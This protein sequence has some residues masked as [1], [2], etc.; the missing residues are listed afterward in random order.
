VSQEIGLISKSAV[1]LAGM[2]EII[3]YLEVVGKG[4]GDCFYS[5]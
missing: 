4:H 5:Q 3:T 2:R 1:E